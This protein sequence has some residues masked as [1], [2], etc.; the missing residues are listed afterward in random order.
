[1][2][3]GAFAQFIASPADLLK[4]HIQ[5]EGRR[6]LLGEPPRVHGL[7]DAFLKVVKA[8]GLRGLWKGEWKIL[9]C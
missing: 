5:M 7:S 6:R 1:M 9:D 8:S 2:T 4:V 3:A